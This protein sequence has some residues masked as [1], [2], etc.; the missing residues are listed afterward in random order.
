V[1]H[2][3]NIRD[4]GFKVHIRSEKWAKHKAPHF[5]IDGSGIDL[6]VRLDKLVIQGRLSPNQERTI[7]AYVNR[8]RAEL[9]SNYESFQANGTYFWIED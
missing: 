4:T 2:I 1:P 8:H 5:H 7:L 3:G 6:S 9:W